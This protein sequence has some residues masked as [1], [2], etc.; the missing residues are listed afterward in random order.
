M[1]MP[2][3]GYVPDPE[4]HALIKEIVRQDREGTLATWQNARWN[5]YGMPAAPADDCWRHYEQLR[6][7]DTK[8]QAEATA[9]VNR[10]AEAREAANAA[11]RDAMIGS[12]REQGRSMPSRSDRSSGG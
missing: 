6:A 10:D 3:G 2:E 1:E 9:Q 4:R 12:L 7:N 11:A 5:I 8:R